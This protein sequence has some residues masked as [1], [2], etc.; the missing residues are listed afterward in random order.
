MNSVTRP[1]ACRRLA[2]AFASQE[3]AEQLADALKA[4]AEQHPDNDYIADALNHANL[5]VEEMAADVEDKM[6]Y[7]TPEEFEAWEARR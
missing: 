2:D 3:A 7:V 4:A 6:E 1:G 5:L